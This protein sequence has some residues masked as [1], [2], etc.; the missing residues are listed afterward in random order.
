MG[1]KWVPRVLERSS[2]TISGKFQRYF[3]GVSRKFQRCSKE[4]FRVFQ[5]ILKDVSRKID[6]C[7]NSFK[8]V[9]RV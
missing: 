3:I 9:S 7:F 2:K 5:G 4:V 8:G 1:F 6:G